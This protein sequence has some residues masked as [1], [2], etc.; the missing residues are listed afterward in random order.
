MILS[1]A[2]ATV[3]DPEADYIYGAWSDIVV[4]ERPGGLI[5]CYLSQKDGSVKMVSVWETAEDHDR[6]LEESSNHP[7]FGFFAA[8]GIDPTHET[9]DV[10]GRL[11]R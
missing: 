1:I 3:D 7:A 5:D 8:C 9:Y 10:I 6:A 11:G 2:H 4:G